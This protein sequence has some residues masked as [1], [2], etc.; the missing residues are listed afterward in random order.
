[1]SRINVVSELTKIFQETLR[2]RDL[3]LTEKTTQSDVA[4]WDSLNHAQLIYAIEQHYDIKFSLTEIVNFTDVGQICQ[5]V[6]KKI[7]K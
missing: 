5:A 7:Q 3:T 2:N 6:E 1:M 4:E